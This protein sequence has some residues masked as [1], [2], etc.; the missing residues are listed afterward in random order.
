MPQI[1]EILKTSHDFFLSQNVLSP[2][3]IEMPQNSNG[4]KILKID[5]Q[6]KVFL[7][8]KKISLKQAS[9]NIYLGWKIKTLKELSS[10]GKQTILRM[11]KYSENKQTKSQI[12]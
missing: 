4:L 6:R 1:L 9:K 7:K 3:N 11:Q 5:M 10:N 2:K 12:K 8:I